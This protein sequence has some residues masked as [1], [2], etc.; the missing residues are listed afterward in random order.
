MLNLCKDH[1]LSYTLIYI[2]RLPAV[3]D[4][5]EEEELCSEHSYRPVF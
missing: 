4:N 3:A 1:Q 5:Q 2:K